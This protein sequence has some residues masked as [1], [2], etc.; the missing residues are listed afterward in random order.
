M[1]NQ[2][3][4][5]PSFAWKI[6][7]NLEEERAAVCTRKRKLN[8]LIMKGEDRSD[9]FV[10]LFDNALDRSSLDGPHREDRLN[11]GAKDLERR[12]FTKRI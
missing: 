5:E 6:R 1:M 7:L 10:K 11:E 3:Q 8:D 4:I 12:S 2:Y 9:R